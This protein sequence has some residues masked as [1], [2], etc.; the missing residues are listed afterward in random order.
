MEKPIE[1]I[2]VVPEPTPADK[3]KQLQE[4]LAQEQAQA[5]Q[6]FDAFVV[7]LQQ[8]GFALRI[9]ETRVNGGVAAIQIEV[10]RK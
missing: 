3:L 10:V 2:A 4:W 1:E 9:V 6:R 7:G 5:Q 8:E